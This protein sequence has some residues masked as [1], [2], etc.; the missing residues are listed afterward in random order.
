MKRLVK[1]LGLCVLS[2]V[3]ASGCMTVGPDY[4]VPKAPVMPEYLAYGD[5]L[6]DTTALAAPEWWKTAFNDPILDQLVEMALAQNLSLRSA[7]LRVLQ[8]RQ[9]LLIAIGNQ[10]PQLQ[11]LNGQAGIAGVVSSPAYEIYDLGFNLAWEAD[12]WGSFKRQIESASATLDASVAGYDGV[13]VSLVAQVAQTY[14]IIRTTQQR[15]AAARQNLALQQESV[16]ITTAKYESGEVDS[17]D[18]DQAKTLFYNTQASVV[19]LEL[20]LQQFKNS[21]AILLG[22]PPFDMSQL[23]GKPQPVPTV[24]PEIAVGMPQDLIRRRPDIRAAERQ[25][26]A[27]S[28]QIGVAVSELYPAFGLG[29]TI[30][31]SVS[32]NTGLSFSDLFSAQTLGYNL[33]GAFQWNIFQY[34]RLR[35]NIRLQDAAFQQLLEDY[36]QTVLQAQGE[37]E[38]AIVAF[39]KSQQ[40]LAAL[41]SAA[42]AAQRAADISTLQYQGGEVGYNTVILTLQ[43]LVS[44]QDQ[45]AAIQGTVTTNL[46]DVYRSLGGGWEVRQS[47]NPLDLIPDAVKDEMLERTKYWNRTFK[48][49]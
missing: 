29:G 6:L 1:I 16:R 26:A 19:S 34:G 45:L 47:Q 3:F 18:V 35:N 41:R 39:F 40:Q 20:S 17:L 42:D 33:F 22:Q 27:Q 13:L 23:L 48:P 11:Q 37:V 12:V 2:A 43:A 8:A 14:L 7:G 44:Q 15:L 46:V 31:T 9:Q 21:L 30:G 5:P 32:T 49:D 38:N 25:M 10:Y 4:Q 28:A 36:R 24:A